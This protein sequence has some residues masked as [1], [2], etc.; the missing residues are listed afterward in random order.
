MALLMAYG[1]R[2]PEFAISTVQDLLPN[3]DIMGTD[4]TLRIIC[5]A[6]LVA[7]VIVV[8]TYIY[9]VFFDYY[10]FLKEREEAFLNDSQ[11]S[12]QYSPIPAQE[13]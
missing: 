13:K 8:M 6:V 12:D 3:A 11:N 5:I 9:L 10:V 4:S 2:I 7:I 1:N